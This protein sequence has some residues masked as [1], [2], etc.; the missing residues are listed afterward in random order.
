MADALFKLLARG[1]VADPG[2]AFAS[3]AQGVAQTPHH[4][5]HGAPA[6]DILRREAADLRLTGV[7]IFPQLDAGAVVEGDEEAV[8]RGRPGEAMRAHPQLVDDQRVQQA[9]EIRARRHLDAV[10]KRFERTRAADALA[11]LQ[12]E[13]ALALASEIGGAG[14]AVVARADDDDIPLLR[15]QLT[16]RRW[17]TDLAHD[18]AG[19]DSGGVITGHRATPVV[20]ATFSAAPVRSLVRVSARNVELLSQRVPT[21]GA[22]ISSTG[23]LCLSAMRFGR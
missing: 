19:R 4:I 22:I 13:H 15:R 9:D 17:Q 7:V 16:H 23:A 14:Q 12:D 11:R 1:R 3:G 20:L 18:C 10:P 8:R 6:G 21:R 5:L 2:V